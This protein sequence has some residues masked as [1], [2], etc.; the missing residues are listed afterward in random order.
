M[1]GVGTVTVGSVFFVSVP[2]IPL[3]GTLLKKA[4]NW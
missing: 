3:S 1:A 2:T 4:K